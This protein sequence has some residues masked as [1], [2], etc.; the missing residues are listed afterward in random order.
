MTAWTFAPGRCF[1]PEYQASISSPFALV[2]VSE[3]RSVSKIFP[4]GIT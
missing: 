4:S 2:T 3:R 1:F